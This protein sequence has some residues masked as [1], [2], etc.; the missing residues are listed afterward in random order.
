MTPTK[1]QRLM[2]IK[3]EYARAQA[4]LANVYKLEEAA[5]PTGLAVLLENDLDQAELILAAQDIMHKLQ[6]MA[7]D[8]A[9]INAQDLFPLVDRMKEAFGLDNAHAFEASAQQ[10]ITNAMNSV[11]LA[12]DEMGNGILR[13]EG[14]MPAN[15]MAADAPAETPNDMADADAEVDTDAVDAAMDDF[16]AADGAAGPE[17]EPLG[18]AR[19]ESIEGGRALNESIILESAGRKLIESQGLDSLISWVLNEAANSMPEEHFRSFATSIAQKA[20]KDPA[21]LAGWIG[22]KQQGMAAM[23]QLAEPTFTQNNAPGLEIVEGKTYKRGDDEDDNWEKKQKDVE[24]KAARKR[25]GDDTVEEG[26]TYKAD[27]DDE[28]ADD[29]AW[30]KKQKDVARKAARKRKGDDS[31]EESKFSKMAESIARLIE[32]NIKTTGKGHAAKVMEAAVAHLA[33]LNL[34]EGDEDLGSALLEAFVSEYGMKPAEYSVKALREFSGFST[35]DKKNGGAALAKIGSDMGKNQSAAKRSV[36]T[37]MASLSGQER[38]AANKMLNKMKK[39]GDVP[40][41]AGEF[42]QKA[43]SMVGENINAAHWP[44]DSMGQYKGEPFST[45]YG[46][47]KANPKGAAKTDTSSSSGN[48]EEPKVEEATPTEEAAPKAKKPKGNPFAKKAEEPKEESVDD[49]K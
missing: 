48:A 23:V 39:D 33:G 2:A 3:E 30:R 43:A 6:N 40:K 37:A 27:Y 42:A 9:K 28:D 11:R 46:K 8:L 10:A 17:D 31:I 36:S 13:L 19:K 25:K 26:K 34:V 1:I 35:T 49:S 44:V 12:K 47:L 38:A 22:K 5:Q 41:N 16:G 21:K 18:R 15:D 7:E 20:A 4:A 29:D 14:K 24:R 32:K 45:D